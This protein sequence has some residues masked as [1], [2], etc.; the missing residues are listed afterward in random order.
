MPRKPLE[1]TQEEIVRRYN[2]YLAK[3]RARGKKYNNNKKRKKID[4]FL[5][6][7]KKKIW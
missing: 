1:L 7:F 5:K 6:E 2:Q 4:T 3:M